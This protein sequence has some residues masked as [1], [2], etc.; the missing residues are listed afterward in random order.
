MPRVV[1]GLNRILLS[2]GGRLPRG[3][4]C[5]LGEGHVWLHDSATLY[6]LLCMRKESAY[7]IR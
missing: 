3:G 7:A 5:L 1:C 4:C 6:I 2:S